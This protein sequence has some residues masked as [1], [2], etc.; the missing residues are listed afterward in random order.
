MNTQSNQPEIMTDEEYAERRENL[1]RARDILRRKPT[2]LFSEMAELARAGELEPPA[3]QEMLA[4]LTPEEI[5]RIPGNRNF[6]DIVGRIQ[7]NTLTTEDRIFNVTQNHI[8]FAQ[9]NGFYTGGLTMA[10]DI[11]ETQKR[12]ELVGGLIQRHGLS[13]LCSTFFGPTGVAIAL[14]GAA[15]KETTPIPE[16]PVSI[17][18]NT[19][20][21]ATSNPLS[22][23][24]MGG[25]AVVNE[26][27]KPTT[28]ATAETTETNERSF[29]EELFEELGLRRSDNG[30]V[31][32]NPTIESQVVSDTPLLDFLLTVPVPSEETDNTQP[33]AA[34]PNRNRDRAG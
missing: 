27:V 20:I 28:P 3:A 11:V 34:R 4:I 19:M 25:L 30:S 22:A 32:R 33:I 16:G 7:N 14:G 23:G 17:V 26:L 10:E 24:V 9:Q 2:M 5:E 18:T 29:E 1:L 31:V 12:D 15:I 8:N 21:G 13:V 6:L